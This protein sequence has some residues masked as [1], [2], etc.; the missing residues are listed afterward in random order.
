[1]SRLP[2]LRGAFQGRVDELRRLQESPPGAFVL[3]QGSSGVGKSRLVRR[4]HETCDEAHYFLEGKAEE[5]AEPYAV[6]RSA[7]ACLQPDIEQTDEIRRV[8]GN[9]ARQLEVVVPA[10]ILRESSQSEISESTSLPVEAVSSTQLAYLLQKLLRIM[11]RHRRLIMFLDDLQWADTASLKVIRILGSNPEAGDCMLVGTHR[12]GYDLDIIR[13]GLHGIVE[14]H[15]DNFSQADAQVLVSDW[16]DQDDVDSLVDVLYQK[17]LG[18]VYYIVTALRILEDRGLLTFS[19]RSRTWTWDTERI[20]E[21]LAVSENVVELV[22]G[23]LQRLPIVSKNVLCVASCLRAK[24]DVEVLEGLM[25]DL[26]PLPEGDSLVSVLRAIAAEGLLEETPGHVLG[27]S[28]VHDRVQ[29]AARN[30]LKGNQEKASVLE[31]PPIEL[32]IGAYLLQRSAVSEDWVLFAAL[33]LLNAHTYED[34]QNIVDLQ[35]L[36]NAEVAAGKKALEKGA[37]EPA[38]TYLM[39]A[40]DLLERDDNRWV[41]QYG[42]CVDVY[43]AAAQALMG[44]GRFVEAHRLLDKCFE[45]ELAEDDKTS[46]QAIMVD[47]MSRQGRNNESVALCRRIVTTRGDCPRVVTMMTATRELRRVK[48]LLE[49][50]SDEEILQLHDLQ[51]DEMKVRFSW[52]FRLYLLAGRARQ[53]ALWYHSILRIL[54][55]SLIHGLAVESVQ[56]MGVVAVMELALLGSMPFAYRMNQL[57]SQLL[58]RFDDKLC[59]ARF[60][61]F[62]AK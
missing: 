17:T 22:V 37:L 2:T 61:Y 36:L 40:V 6:I 29:E 31:T 34:M 8:L 3:I 51:D 46:A 11:T 44:R 50:R 15:L 53:V 42:L 23:N 25:S 48:R 10:A 45:K 56:S 7:C 12:T 1:M 26:H 60:T 5:N 14:I 43:Q 21:D 55:L 38:S 28:F 13:T 41:T 30:L 47:L 57:C 35:V 62:M 16:L 58:H 33:D 39:A 18:N 19:Y 54:R 20:R 49:S 59:W 52:L 32:R 4:F 27:F 9:E 24:I